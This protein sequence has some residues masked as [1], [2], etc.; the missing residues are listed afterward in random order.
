[1]NDC[2]R[3]GFLWNGT[4][5]GRVDE[6]AGKAVYIAGDNS[7]RAVLMIH[8]VFGW[9]VN[10]ARLL[11]DHYAKEIGATVYLP[12]FFDGGSAK[13]GDLSFKPEGNSMKM[14]ISPSFDFPGF[15]AKNSPEARF[16]EIVASARKLREQY[17]FV[18]AV[19]FCWG[20]STQ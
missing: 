20:G 18:G 9:D 3:T 16:P 8:D 12:D 6:H 15:W 5:T 4:P 13:E 7:K 11:A 17:D 2:C 1:M 10:N 14:E 19:G